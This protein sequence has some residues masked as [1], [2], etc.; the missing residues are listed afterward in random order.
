MKYTKKYPI[1]PKPDKQFSGA[2]IFKYGGFKYPNGGSF[3]DS[4]NINTSKPQVNKDGTTTTTPNPTGGNSSNTMRYIGAGIGTAGNIV[5]TWTQPSNLTTQ[6]KVENTAQGVGDT[7]AG[8]IPGVNYATQASGTTRGLLDA[9]NKTVV[10]PNTGKTEAVRTT[11]ESVLDS[12]LEPQHNQDITAWTNVISDVFTGDK[13]ASTGDY[14]STFLGGTV[15]NVV[16]DLIDGGENQEQYKKEYMA[17]ANWSK[18]QGARNFQ[19]FGGYKNKFP[20]GGN[21]KSE[22]TGQSYLKDQVDDFSGKNFKTHE[23]GGVDVGGNNEVEK[24]EIVYKDYVF[25]DRLKDAKGNSY[26]A[27]AKKLISQIK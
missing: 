14:L 4:S 11:G 1:H 6:G 16:G 7:V 8:F 25:S 26:A 10:N 13:T 3:Y 5:N 27:R 15:G 24:G 2:S 21:M 17:N 9:N 19:A 12:T 18:D 23:G 20:Y 22:V